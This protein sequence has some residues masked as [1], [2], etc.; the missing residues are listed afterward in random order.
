ML[1]GSHIFNVHVY[2]STIVIGYHIRKWYWPIQIYI[3]V[4]TW[5]WIIT[6]IIYVTL[7][8]PNGVLVEHYS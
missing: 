4:D 6:I 7:Y 5:T 3:I 1:F 8:E 2:L